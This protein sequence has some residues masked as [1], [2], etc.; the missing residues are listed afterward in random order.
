SKKEE[1]FVHVRFIEENSSVNMV[2]SK[3]TGDETKKWKDIALEQVPVILENLQA[4]GVALKD[5]AILVRKNDEGQKIAAYLLQYKNS[6]QAKATCHYDVVSN[7]SLRIDGAAS[8][9]LLLGAMRYLLNPDDAIARAQLGF[10]F[11]R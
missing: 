9:N 4:K 1:G 11:A 5:I 6:P 8:V 3:E 7:E 2:N 10:E